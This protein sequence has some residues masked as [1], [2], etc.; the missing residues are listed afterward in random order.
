M[1]WLGIVRIARDSL[2]IGDVPY[3]KVVR[4][5]DEVT[6]MTFGGNTRDLGSI[7]EEMDK[8]TTLHQLSKRKAYSAWRRRRQLQ[9]VASKLSRDNV[10][11][12]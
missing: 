8:T 2:G 3:V 1:L 7:G 12:F 6:W 11:E 5:F 9:A 10:M 4:E